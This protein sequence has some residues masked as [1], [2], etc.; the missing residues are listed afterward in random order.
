MGNRCLIAFK[1]KEAERKDAEIP[2]IYLHWNGGRNSIEAMLDAAKRLGI[3][4]ESSYCMARMTQ[5]I[6]NYFG[7]T[8]SIGCS[9]VAQW[10]LDFLDN[11]VYWV[12]NFEIY[13]RT[14]TYEGY[15]EQSND[16]HE[17]LV[18]EIIEANSSVLKPTE[19]VL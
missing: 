3:R 11:G 7:G 1:P 10:S 15:K 4:G 14:D 13:D 9:T 18:E 17:H 6:C 19:T 12:D 2:C 5:I 16:N 8:L